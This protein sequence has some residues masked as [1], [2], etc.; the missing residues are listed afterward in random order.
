MGDIVIDPDSSEVSHDRSRERPSFG[1]T[2]V[3]DASELVPNRSFLEHSGCGAEARARTG[4][5]ESGCMRERI[6]I[7]K[8]PT[9][10]RGMMSE[11]SFVIVSAG[12]D[13]GGWKF[14][15]DLVSI[16]PMKGGFW[17]TTRWLERMNS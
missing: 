10:G 16:E 4:R 1:P 14:Y 12:K 9:R 17:S 11:Q 7:E 5:C 8:A 15:L 13:G 2:Q 3:R 6:K